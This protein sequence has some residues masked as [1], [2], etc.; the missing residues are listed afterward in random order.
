[1]RSQSSPNRP[2]VGTGSISGRVLVQ[3]KG[4]PGVRLALY[5]GA[6]DPKVP[7]EARTESD[8]EGRYKYNGLPPGSYK[9]G[10]LGGP[11]V[12]STEAT[13][14]LAEGENATSV[15]LTLQPGG[16]ITGKVTD[17]DNKPMV[18][19]YVRLNDADV[20]DGM[21]LMHL[22]TAIGGETDDR[23]IYRYYGV[24]PG[25]YR[26][27]CDGREVPSRPGVAGKHYSRTFHPEVTDLASATIIEVGEGTEHL[28]VDIRLSAATKSYS[29]AGRVVDADTGEPISN[30]SVLAALPRPNG[31]GAEKGGESISGLRG[32]FELQG[33]RPGQWQLLADSGYRHPPDGPSGFSEPLNVELREEDSTG[34]EVR[35]KSGGSITGVA[36]IEGDTRALDLSDLRAEVVVQHDGI[37][38]VMPPSFRPVKIQPD[39][40]FRVDGLRPGLATFIEVREPG[41]PRIRLVRIEH[42]GQLMPKGIELK[43]GESP[44]GVRLVFAYATASVEGQV[45]TDGG[46]LPLGTNLNVYAVALGANVTYSSGQTDPRGKFSIE[47]LAPGQYELTAY[48]TTNRVQGT[49]VKQ[50]V[51]LGNGE[52]LKVT[53]TFTLSQP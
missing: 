50:T 41:I 48:P 4:V 29:I 10:P 23:G 45:L 18:G 19:R 49:A 5:R 22:S 11:Y 14:T 6:F 20:P 7:R 35:F 51:V 12:W 34:V 13:V 47:G 32:E 27:S 15:D 24:L 52:T 46:T 16:V 26:V 44:S 31:I 8:M 42:N 21:S 17:P 39:G 3:G 30:I 9:L 36:V 28:N 2:M 40:R 53:L 25:R 33:L 1:M 37:N 43:S 38:S